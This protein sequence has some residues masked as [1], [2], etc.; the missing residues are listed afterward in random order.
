MADDKHKAVSKYTEHFF[1]GEEFG[2]DA[3]ETDFLG[4]A[5]LESDDTLPEDDLENHGVVLLEGDE[6][7]H[8]F[9]GDESKVYK[10]KFQAS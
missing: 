2:L 9:F 7:E 8:D 5:T 6:D 10:L 4:Q 3:A 1:D